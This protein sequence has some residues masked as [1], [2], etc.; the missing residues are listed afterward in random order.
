LARWRHLQG[1]VLQDFGLG[2][3]TLCHA[4][5]MRKEGHHRFLIL[6]IVAV[7]VRPA[8]TGHVPLPRTQ[9]AVYAPQLVERL[10]VPAPVKVV[11]LLAQQNDR[12][13]SPGDEQVD[14]LH[15]SP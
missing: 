15:A 8:E 13:R 4:R 5:V 2:H 6:A 12:L 11:Q 7:P 14:H 10:L 3:G 9:Q 1:R